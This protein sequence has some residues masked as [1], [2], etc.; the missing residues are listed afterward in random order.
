[1]PNKYATAAYWF[2]NTS[3][4]P[5]AVTMPIRTAHSNAVGTSTAGQRCVQS[6][7]LNG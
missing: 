6:V 7:S 5:C 4:L 3:V 1:M 2:A